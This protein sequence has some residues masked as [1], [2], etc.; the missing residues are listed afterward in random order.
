MMNLTDEDKKLSEIFLPYY[1][2]RVQ[3]FKNEDMNLAY[4]TSAETAKNILE[5]KEIWLRNANAM[6]DFSEVQY[7]VD[8]LRK[9][10]EKDSTKQKLKKLSPAD[11]FNDVFEKIFD[12]NAGEYISHKFNTYIACFTE[13][14]KNENKLGRL[15]MWRAYGRNNGI[16][17]VLK[18]ELL[19]KK[20]INKK[21]Y[22][23]PVAYFADDNE[24]LEQEVN[25]II[26]N[27][28]DNETFIQK[29]NPQKIS[30]YLK[31]TLRFALVSIK[32][33]GFSEE[34]E[35]RLVTHGY[36]IEKL[37]IETPYGVPQPV[38]KLKFELDFIEKIIIG[39]TQYKNILH[40]AFSDLVS[41]NK[42]VYSHI[43]YRNIT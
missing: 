10:F 43:P 16:A 42:I 38:Y 28:E 36:D 5:K 7:G 24:R 33:S 25:K 4:Y 12:E 17:I 19:S 14:N 39:P 35:W 27:I 22:F 30:N 21:I 34:K 11:I 9:I 37:C 32:H 31:N 26:K 20:L 15:S 29:I 40:K 3:K 1:N 13:H 6:N 18:K 23:S 2:E 41:E 8:L